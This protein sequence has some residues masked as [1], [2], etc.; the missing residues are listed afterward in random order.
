MESPTVASSENNKSI[1]L[2]VAEALQIDYGKRIVRI[3]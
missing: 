2:K 3:V 1:N